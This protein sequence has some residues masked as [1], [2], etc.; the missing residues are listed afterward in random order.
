MYVV[1]EDGGFDFEPSVERQEQMVERRRQVSR[2]EAAAAAGRGDGASGHHFRNFKNRQVCKY[3]LIGTCIHQDDD[4]C[5]YLHQLNYD[6]MPDC[7]AFKQTG[8]CDD[9]TC[10]LRHPTEPCRDYYYGYCSRGSRCKSLHRPA[11]ET[12]RPLFASKKYL[13]SVLA[14]ESADQVLEFDA[15]TEQQIEKGERE[16]WELHVPA[17]TE[18]SAVGGRQ[19]PGGDTGRAFASGGHTGRDRE[20]SEPSSFRSH[21]HP[22]RGAGAAICKPRGT[23]VPLL[24]GA[25]KDSIAVYIIKSRTIENIWTSVRERVWASGRANTNEL[26]NAFRNFKHVILLF[27]AMESGSFQGYARMESFPT[28]SL[29][30]GLWGEHLRLGDNFK[31]SWVK[32]CRLPFSEVGEVRNPLNDNHEIRKSRDGQV[33]RSRRSM[34]EGE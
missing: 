34:R 24:S 14:P 3:W 16:F 23:T 26:S 8:H 32:Q 27:S 22:G 33:R 5:G 10:R 31:V 7:D 15:E 4:R 28:Q 12:Q 30:P 6:K 9:P 1:E 13:L 21:R 19:D 18:D 2:A 25:D 20:E 29:K 17:A 11:A